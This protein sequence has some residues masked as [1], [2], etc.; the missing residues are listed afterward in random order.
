MV[1]PTGRISAWLVDGIEEVQSIVVDSG[2]TFLNGM[3]GIAA[4]RVRMFSQAVVGS[5]W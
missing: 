5:H 4:V 2:E 3:A 1:Q